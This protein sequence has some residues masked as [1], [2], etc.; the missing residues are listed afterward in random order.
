M[1]LFTRISATLTGSL[2]SLVSQFENHEAV[3]AAAIDEVRAAVAKANVRTERTRKERI[4]LEERIHTLARQASQWSERAKE[5]A[6]HD[7]PRALA[8]LARK[9]AA[10]EQHT[11]LKEALSQQLETEHTMQ[12]QLHELEKRLQQ[13]QQQHQL[14]RSRQSSSDAMRTIQR[15]QTPNNEAIDDVFERWEMQ[16]AASDYLYDTHPESDTLESDFLAAE[17]QA[18]LKAELD[19]LMNNTSHKE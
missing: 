15:L 4:K 19:Q 6:A 8:C 17:E 2:D 12:A 13:L 3:A 9:R 7:E 16:L 11:A 5:V 10:E 18:S 1:N 14:M